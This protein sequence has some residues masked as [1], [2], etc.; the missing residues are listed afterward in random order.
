MKERTKSRNL[1]GQNKRQKEAKTDND[2]KNQKY[3]NKKPG[4]ERTIGKPK[5]RK[6]EA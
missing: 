2:N 1:H 6:N 5:E 3:I 4:Q